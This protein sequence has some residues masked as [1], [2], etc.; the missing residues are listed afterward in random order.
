MTEKEFFDK[1]KGYNGPEY[2]GAPFPPFDPAAI[3]PIRFEDELRLKD[4]EIMY[5]AKRQQV[6]LHWDSQSWSDNTDS[7]KAEIR[8]CFHH[9]GFRG[10]VIL[11]LARR[12]DRGCS[13]GRHEY[14]RFTV[15]DRILKG[16][17]K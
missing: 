15:G 11:N 3:N 16:E 5:D 12:G 9:I 10:K 8:R 4:Y 17:C 13:Y 1:F 14:I 6:K 7:L 2:R